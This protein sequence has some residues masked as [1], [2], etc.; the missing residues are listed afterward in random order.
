MEKCVKGDLCEL[1]KKKRAINEWFSV[2]ES[3]SMI[4]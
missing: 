4:K 2:E 3:V 1:F